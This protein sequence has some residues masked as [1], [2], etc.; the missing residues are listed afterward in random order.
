MKHAAAFML[1]IFLGMTT[2]VTAQNQQQVTAKPD[3]SGIP[4]GT[5]ATLLEPEWPGQIYILGQ[6]LIPLEAQPR[7]EVVKLKAFGMGGGTSAYVFKGASSPVKAG[8]TP[9]FVVK[10]EIT[11]D[12]DGLIGMN[13]LTVDKKD[14]KLLLVKM[15][16]MAMSNKVMNDGAVALKFAKYGSSLKCSPVSPLTP[17]E[18]VIATKSAVAY[19]FS[20][21]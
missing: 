4:A 10:M 13:R 1:A 9:E 5:S 16:A 6:K 21:E 19:L 18:Y 8:T 20:V 17:G 15:G 7:N 11:E 14:R 12:P 3:A 2:I